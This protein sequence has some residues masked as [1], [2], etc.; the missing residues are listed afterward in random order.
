M[1][2]T[3]PA[4]ITTSPR[5]W[6]NS[7][8]AGKSACPRPAATAARSSTN[9]SLTHL[10]QNP[11]EDGVRSG[12]V[13]RLEFHAVPGL[14][15]GGRQK[16]LFQGQYGVAGGAL[17]GHLKAGQGLDVRFVDLAA[18]RLKIAFGAIQPG[19]RAARRLFNGLVHGGSAAGTAPAIHARAPLF[20]PH[21]LVHL[22]SVFARCFFH[23]TSTLWEAL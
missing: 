2:P 13:D 18:I 10:A 14:Q 16:I 22:A 5:P 8:R 11:G 20:S 6:T 12:H 15:S 7:W 17:H 21:G 23:G 1:W 4:P 19:P 9:N 3:S